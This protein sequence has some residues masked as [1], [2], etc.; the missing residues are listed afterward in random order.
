MTAP[1]APMVNFV[2]Y[3]PAT[4]RL[5]HSG[6]CPADV[7]DIQADGIANAEVMK[8]DELPEN[9]SDVLVHRGWRRCVSRL[10]RDTE[11]DA[12]LALLVIEAEAR[13]DAHFSARIA[14]VIGPLGQVH[15][16]KR[17]QAEAGAGPLVADEA[18]RAAILVRASEQDAELAAL[19]AERRALKARVREAADPQQIEAPL[20]L[21][22][23]EH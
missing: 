11:M 14:Q 12:R 18:D 5:H 13:I 15:A 21:L 20:A 16:L 9:N 7:L 4:R 1:R 17:A 2:V 22:T 8:V 23:A 19:D 10:L 6:R 3:D